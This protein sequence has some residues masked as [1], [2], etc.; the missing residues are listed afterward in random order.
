MTGKE[1]QKEIQF[2]HVLKKPSGSGLNMP[3][4]FDILAQLA[5][6]P[7]RITIYELL[8]LSK[9][10]REALRDALANSESFLTHM[11][12]IPGGDTQPSCPECHHIQPKVPTITFTAEDMLLK[13]NKHDRPL[14]YTGYIGSTCIERV[15]VD[16][17]FALSIIPKR[18]LYFLGIPLYRLS[19]TTT[20]IYGFNAGSSHPLGKIRLHC[21]IGSLKSE[22]TCY[23]IDADTS[24]NLLLG[25]PWIH[26]N[27]IIPSN[28]HQC[29]KYVEDD[30]IVRTVFAEKKP[31]KGV[32]NYFTDALLYQKVSETSK[33]SLPDNNDSGNKADSESEGDTPATLVGE[34]I[35][36]Y[37]NPQYNTPFEDENEWV[38]ND[39]ISFN[40]PASVEL[41]ESVTDNSLH[42]PLHKLSTSSTSVECIEGSVLV[43]PPSKKVLAQRPITLVLMMINS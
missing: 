28:L 22:M 7:A 35:I 17:G 32:K 23:V 26:A 15:Q 41:L 38:I 43:V 2:D 8:H 11:P 34:P 24:Y 40:Y 29:F 33:D 39:T 6:I 31:F 21:R 3:F 1:K 10:T 27:W 13:D 18:L 25:R 14:Y 5:N 20:T 30:V 9:E 4:R 36:A 37:F 19:A 16:P 12:E 42:M